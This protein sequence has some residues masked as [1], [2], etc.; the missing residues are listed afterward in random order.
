MAGIV[1]VLANAGMPGLLK[2][3][4]TDQE[5]PNQRMSQLYTT[6]VPYP[7]ECV[8]AIEVADTEDLEKALHKAFAPARVNARRE[9]FDLKAD[10]VLAIL[11]AWLGGKDATPRAAREVAEGT[12][13]ADREAI[14]QAKRRRPSLDFFRLGIRV[15]EILKFIDPRE[16]ASENTESLE[17]KV[18][19]NRKVLFQEEEMYLTRA[20]LR[21]LGEPDDKPIRPTPLWSYNGRNLQ[22]LY[23]ELHGRQPE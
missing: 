10:Q 6:G 7:F 19:G 20:T 5:G 11:E 21:A 2:I 4:R 16:N 17:A 12:E 18:V 14:K 13:E 3:G 15:G 22:D 9:F 8:K 23:D 1:Y